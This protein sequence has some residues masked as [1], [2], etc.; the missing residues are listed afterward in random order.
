MEV[1]QTER[2]ADVKVQ[3]PCTD[4]SIVAI[5]YSRWISGSQHMHCN[6]NIVYNYVYVL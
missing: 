2:D 3:N 4:L 5:L 1:R 6:N